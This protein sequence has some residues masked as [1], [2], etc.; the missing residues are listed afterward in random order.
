M[1]LRRALVPALLLLAFA[2][3]IVIIGPFHNFPVQDDWDYARTVSLLL[4]SGV[5]ERSEIA[6]A[7]EVFSALWGL[8]FVRLFGFSCCASRRSC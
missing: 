5:F 8:L 4:R 6:Q 1:G 3:L 7:S 2:S